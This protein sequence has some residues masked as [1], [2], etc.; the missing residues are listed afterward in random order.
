MSPL[1]FGQP[2][3]PISP[4]GALSQ[5]KI[6]V[7]DDEVQKLKT[8]LEVLPI[9]RPNW[10]NGHKDQSCGIPRDWLVESVDYWQNKYNCIPQF[11]VEVQDD[12][13]QKYSVHFAA[14]FSEN[15]DAIPI[16]LSHGW[17]GSFIEFMPILLKLKEQYASSPEKLPYHV[18]VPSIIG[19]GFSSPPPLDKD[20]IIKDNCRL[21]HKAML[22]LGFGKR[23]Y[24]T[25]GGDLGGPIAETLAAV[26]EP[27]KAAH[28]NIYFI[29]STAA[30]GEPAD[31][32]EKKAI[33]KGKKFLQTGMAIGEK[34][35]EWPDPAHVPSLDT[36]LTNVSIYWFTGTFPTSIWCYRALLSGAPETAYEP[37]TN[38]K[39]KGL[40]W[41]PYEIGAVPKEFIR[42]DKNI[43]HFYEHH[44]GG[45]FAALEVPDLLWADFEDFIAKVWKQ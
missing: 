33:E 8:L 32:L 36:I 27:A 18:I 41:F 19:F 39:P 6:D 1:L 13:G 17:P 10:E 37:I 43:T 16:H 23:G 15:K 2:P 40:S 34:M 7:P 4:D 29:P 35:L 3:F 12:D 28:L 44:E 9:P 5:F 45:H 42:N 21:F 22:A 14:L 31:P 24:I 30:S 20:F 11:K 25:Q 26:Y 38:G